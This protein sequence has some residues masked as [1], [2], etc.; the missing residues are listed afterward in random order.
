[1]G[2]LAIGRLTVGRA[3]LRRVE[4]GELTV[5]R[6]DVG[7]DGSGGKLTA[8]AL[9]HAAPG[10]GDAL[11][12]LLIEHEAASQPGTLLFRAHRS[13]TDPDRFL[14]CEAYADEAAFERHA[15][16]PRFGDL[17]EEAAGKGLL[18][19]S[20]GDPLEIGFYLAI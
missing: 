9:V 6:L 2:A 20:G 5:G 8:L 13:R 11:A 18:A 7:A 12:R 15:Q 14:F 3:R 4:I 1:V 10:K 16:A 17:V 19:A